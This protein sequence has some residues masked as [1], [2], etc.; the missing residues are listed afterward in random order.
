MQQWTP[1]IRKLQCQREE[2]NEQN[3]YVVAIVKR[4]AERTENQHM[5][6]PM[7]ACSL[8]LQ[9]SGNIERTITG[10]RLYSSNLPQGGLELSCTLC[11]SGDTKLGRSYK[12]STNKNINQY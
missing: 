4:T 9:Q 7:A 8:F 11:F 1:F 3:H 2:A 10:V 6:E 12:L 5:H